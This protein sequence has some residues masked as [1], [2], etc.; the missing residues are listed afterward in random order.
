MG[1]R[2]DGTG[3]ANALK[4]ALVV[5]MVD[6]RSLLLAEAVQNMQTDDGKASLHE[7][8]I[9]IVANVIT[10]SIVGGAWAALDEFGSGSEMDLFNPALPKYVGGK[11]WNPARGRDLTIRSRP[12]APGQTD[13]FGKPVNGKGK[14]GIDLE[15]LG[16]VNAQQPSHAIQTAMRWM[17][18]GE[19]RSKIHSVVSTFPFGRFIICNVKK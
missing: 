13:I 15:E 14:G 1:I 2:F 16:V 9:E 12:D 19:M 4:A 17:R 3:C 10:A 5:A 18:N 11:L 6:L 8:D 7:G